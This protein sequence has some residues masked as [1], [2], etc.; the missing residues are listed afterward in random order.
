[1]PWLDSETWLGA[2]A[3]CQLIQGKWRGQDRWTA[4][5]LYQQLK[6]LTSLPAHFD[7][8][9]AGAYWQLIQ[10][11]WRERRP[12][13]RHYQQLHTVLGAGETCT[14]TCQGRVTLHQIELLQRE[15]GLSQMRVFKLFLWRKL[16]LPWKVWIRCY[17]FSILAYETKLLNPCQARAIPPSPSF[18]SL[19]YYSEYQTS[20]ASCWSIHFKKFPTV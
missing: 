17:Q 7:V 14:K 1:M 9:G 20:Q 15:S 6:P 10:G 2:V 4:V 3:H 13:V 11:K 8:H 19:C 16:G 5:P 12:A 18:T